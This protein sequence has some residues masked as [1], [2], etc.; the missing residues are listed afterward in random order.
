MNDL[1]KKVLPRIAILISLIGAT[2]KW[3]KKLFSQLTT[4]EKKNG[5]LLIEVFRK[6]IKP[7]I[8]G[9]LDH[10]QVAIY[11]LSGVVRISYFALFHAPKTMWEDL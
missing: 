7:Q 8:E 5:F 6:R 11:Y 4:Y 9:H 10:L 3:L 1:P 2:I